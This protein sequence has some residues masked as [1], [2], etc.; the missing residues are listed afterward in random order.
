MQ[1]YEVRVFYY[2][3]LTGKKSLM[4][5]IRTRRPWWAQVVRLYYEL[6]RTYGPGWLSTEVRPAMYF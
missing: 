1:G 6:P 4:K 2:S 3:L 5:V